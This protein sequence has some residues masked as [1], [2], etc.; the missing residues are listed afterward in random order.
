VIMKFPKDEKTLT[1]VYLTDIEISLTTWEFNLDEC[2]VRLI[3]H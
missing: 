2:F 3:A 1:K